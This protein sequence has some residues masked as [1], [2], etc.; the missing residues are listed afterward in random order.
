[1][2]KMLKD[3]TVLTKARFIR[4]TCKNCSV[5]MDK[6]IILNG[7]KFCK[8]KCRIEFIRKNKKKKRKQYDYVYPKQNLDDDIS[9]DAHK[10]SC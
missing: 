3:G 1:M 9:W 2:D 10:D 7:G 6:S 8:K 4:T 5:E